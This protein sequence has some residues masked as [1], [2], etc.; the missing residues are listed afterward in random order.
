[1]NYLKAKPIDLINNG[2]ILWSDNFSYQHSK[3]CLN[4]WNKRID[5]RIYVRYKFWITI[6]AFFRLAFN[7]SIT[8]ESQMKKAGKKLRDLQQL[9]S[10]QYHRNIIVT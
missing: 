7:L 9:N 8:Y 2:Y 1:M 5:K 4:F 6:I 3:I 10:I